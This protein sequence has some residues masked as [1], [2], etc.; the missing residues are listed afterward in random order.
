L[1][2][3]DQAHIHWPNRG[4]IIEQQIEKILKLTRG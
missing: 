1:K 2:S 4:P 3:K